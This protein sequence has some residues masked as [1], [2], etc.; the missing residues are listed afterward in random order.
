LEQNYLFQLLREP[1][2]LLLRAEQSTTDI[3]HNFGVDAFIFCSLLRGNK[4]NKPNRAVSAFPERQQIVRPDV[5]GVG[6]Q[7][8][9]TG[10]ACPDA[11]PGCGVA[12]MRIEAVLLAFDEGDDIRR[13]ISPAARAVG[14]WSADMADAVVPAIPVRFVY[15]IYTIISHNISLG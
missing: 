13:G 11:H 15:A 3:D 4:R 9:V 1:S 12:F 14:F 8:F 6:L 5:I 2:L 7:E 10:W